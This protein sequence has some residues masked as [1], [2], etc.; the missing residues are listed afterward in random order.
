MDR[1]AE[2]KSLPRRDSEGKLDGTRRRRDAV[3][4]RRV[5]CACCARASIAYGH[6]R[7]HVSASL[8]LPALISFPAS[9]LPP[10]A[11]KDKARAAGISASSF[12]DLG[13]ELEKQKQEL[14]KNKVIGKPVG[15]VEGPVKVCMYAHIPYLIPIMNVARIVLTSETNKRVAKWAKQN[16]GVQERSARDAAVFEEPGRASYETGRAVLERKAQKYELLK[17]GRTGGYSDKQYG[18]LLVDV[19]ASPLHAAVPSAHRRR[20]GSSTRSA[21]TITSPTVMT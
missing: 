12:M 7:Q 20:G 13:A 2:C 5:V 4:T 1:C 19:S 14:T 21:T 11:P 8:S 9:P 15:H 17:K 6:L 16:A 18:E 10:M 3:D